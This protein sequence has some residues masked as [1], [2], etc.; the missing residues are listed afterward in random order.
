M[1]CKQ[2][3]S[4]RCRNDLKAPALVDTYGAARL[5][6]LDTSANQIFRYAPTVEGY[7]GAPEPYFASGTKVD[8]SGARDMTIDG[9]IWLLYPDHIGRYQKGQ[10]VNFELKDLDQPFS[11]PSALFTG[12]DDGAR[13]IHHLYIADTGNGRI[14]KL[15]KDGK[16]VRQFRP[17]EGKV[18][19]ELRD[20]VV[21]EVG[22]RVYFLSGKGLYLSDIPQGE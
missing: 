1:S 21:D 4:K 20:L 7:G 5:Y 12:P 22:G 14:V 6:V 2:G 17:Q 9:E 3:P 16:L 13:P 15:T 19:N 8:L 11:S 18:F 10:P